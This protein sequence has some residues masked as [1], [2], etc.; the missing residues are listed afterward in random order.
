MK[1]VLTPVIIQSIE[2]RLNSDSSKMTPFGVALGKLLLTNLCNKLGVS[3]I[4]FIAI[5]G[6]ARPNK[7]GIVLVIWQ[8][9]FADLK[10]DRDVTT[11]LR[12]LWRAS[13]FN[14]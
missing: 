5:L 3:N 7:L 9:V 6:D 10:Q 2:F 4:L 1:C 14:S 13:S 12:Q 8:R 11:L